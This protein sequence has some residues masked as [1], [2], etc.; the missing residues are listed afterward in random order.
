MI[1]WSP[2]NAD[3]IGTTQW[4]TCVSGIVWRHPHFMVMLLQKLLLLYLIMCAIL[5]YCS[6]P[7]LVQGKMVV[8]D[9]ELRIATIAL[10]ISAE[11]EYGQH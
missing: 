2:F 10:L 4:H 5:T 11:P 8:S 3:I 1:Q 7:P 9:S 6:H